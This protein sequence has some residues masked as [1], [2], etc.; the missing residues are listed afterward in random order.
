MI[1]EKLSK[2]Y[3]VF[4]SPECDAPPVFNNGDLV[5]GRRGAGV[6][7]GEQNWVAEATSTR[8]RQR[9][10]DRVSHVRIQQRIHPDLQRP[11]GLPQPERGASAA[12]SVHSNAAA[13]LRVLPCIAPDWSRAVV[14]DQCRR[15]KNPKQNVVDLACFVPLLPEQI[16]DFDAPWPCSFWTNN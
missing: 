5:T 8:F 1:F 6:Y 2:F 13:I 7:W 4:D 14:I 16:V 12:R 9:A 11:G 15:R 3:V 10:M